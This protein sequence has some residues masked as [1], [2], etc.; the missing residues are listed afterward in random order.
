M[1]MFKNIKAAREMMKDMDP[2]QM[3]DLMNQA[4][5]Y[6]VE[7]EEMIRRIVREEL[8]KRGLLGVKNNNSQS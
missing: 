3:Q 5:N 1:N 8:D 7:M 6:Q 4:G 2:D